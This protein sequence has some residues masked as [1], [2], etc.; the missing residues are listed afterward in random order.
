MIDNI[1]RSQ[2]DILFFCILLV[3]CSNI[4]AI[5]LK[6]ISN[7]VSSDSPNNIPNKPLINIQA[8]KPNIKQINPNNETSTFEFFKSF[9]SSLLNIET[10]REQLK[11]PYNS[12]IDDL[13]NTSSKKQFKQKIQNLNFDNFEVKI[14]LIPKC[15]LN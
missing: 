7:I 10:I 14:A 4:N 12:V 6:T 2:T 11:T 15:D 8:Q 5:Q 13:T 1:H 9:I 3:M